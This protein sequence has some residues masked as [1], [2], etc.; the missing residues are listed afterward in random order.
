M[1]DLVWLKRESWE[2][3]FRL[4]KNIQIRM[5]PAVSVPAVNFTSTGQNSRIFLDLPDSSDAYYG[6]FKVINAT[7]VYQSS[8]FLKEMGKKVNE[9]CTPS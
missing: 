5:N 4:L 2:D 3:L 8:L 7:S 6:Y 9:E 1:N